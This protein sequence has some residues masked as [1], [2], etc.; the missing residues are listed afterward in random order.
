MESITA[1]PI[2]MEE[3][4]FPTAEFRKR[5]DPLQHLRISLRTRQTLANYGILSQRL[6][7]CFGQFKI[8][9]PLLAACEPLIFLGFSKS[10]NYTRT[11]GKSLW[12]LPFYFVNYHFLLHGNM[13][14]LAVERL[15]VEVLFYIQGEMACTSSRKQGI[16]SVIILAANILRKAAR[17]TYE[18]RLWKIWRAI[19]TP[20]TCYYCASMNG[21]ILAVMIPESRKFQSTPIVNA[22]Q[23]Q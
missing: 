7:L 17:V 13:Q 3:F 12:D 2:A 23:K 11:K 18:S 21:R 15:Y 4:I 19:I 16:L 9:T 20:G 8:K 22:M 10:Y 1:L 5:N 14:L 6:L